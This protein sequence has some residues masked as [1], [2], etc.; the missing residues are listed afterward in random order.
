V[1]AILDVGAPQGLITAE[2]WQAIADSGVRGVYCRCGNGNNPPDSTF[3]ANT[4]GARAVG[5]AVGAYAVGFPLPLDNGHP[6]RDPRTQALAHYGQSGGLGSKPG[7]MP[8]CMDFEWPLPVDWTRWGVAAA[9]TREWATEYRD[10]MTRLC[11]ARPVLYTYPDFFTH[12]LAGA[13]PEEIAEFGEWREWIARYRVVAP[14]TLS[15]WVAPTLWQK[16]DGG[17]KLPSGAPVDE[18]EFLGDEDAWTEF[19]SA[20][21][22]TPAAA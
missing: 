15:P 11:P 12:V 17:G 16:S 7:E 3:R 9:Q 22:T 13:S 1:I 2:H 18:D 10:A 21:E 8:P 6:G 14:P 4:D 5:L 20:D 19:L